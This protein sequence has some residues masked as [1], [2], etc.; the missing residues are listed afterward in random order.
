[1]LRSADLRTWTSGGLA[2]NP[3]GVA[4]EEPQ[5]AVSQD[6]PGTLVM[7]TR[8]LNLTGGASAAARDAYYRAN[9]AH[10][11]T[12]TSTDAGLTWS[13]MTLDE[14]L[15]NYYVKT[16]FTRDT[17]GR[18]LA[19]FNTLAG[20]F[21]GASASKPD[22]YREVLCYKV[23]PPG[24]PWEPG[25]GERRQRAGPAHRQRRL[26][27]REGV[28]RRQAAHA[29]GPEERRLE[30]AQGL[31]RLGEDLLIEYGRAAH[32]LEGEGGQLRSGPPVPRRRRGSRPR[33]RWWWRSPP[34]PPPR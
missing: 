19:I 17:A 30:H 8:T 20:P 16:F 4:I 18:Y 21:T 3:P 32:G 34:H 13:P 7:V 10:C 22:Q 6:D 2:E 28:Q 14:S 11:A 33:P 27:R 24:E 15:P 31:R 26:L 1:M 29:D 5:I 23:R 12:A 25:P 9:A